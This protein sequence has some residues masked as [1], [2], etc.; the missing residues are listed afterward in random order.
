[1]P[2][3]SKELEPLIVKHTDRQ[4][5]PKQI[6]KS[7]S[8][9]AKQ[10]QKSLSVSP[11]QSQKSASASPKLLYRTA[12]VSPKVLQKSES[13]SPKLTQKS[14]FVSPKHTKK[15]A[16]S[17]GFYQPPK[18]SIVEVD[19]QFPRSNKSI[20]KK[21]LKPLSI[22]PNVNEAEYQYPLPGAPLV[23]LTMPTPDI[24]TSQIPPSL[25]NMSSGAQSDKVKKHAQL[26][27]E[28]LV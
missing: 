19:Y 28:Y 23:K 18:P 5:S 8:L 27:K 2:T 6:K 3:K 9:S 21:E 4:L 17:V 16:P 12:S 1:M 7:T 11:T 13:L 25:T 10:F 15:Q 24:Q 22:K 14:I 26:V 20:Y